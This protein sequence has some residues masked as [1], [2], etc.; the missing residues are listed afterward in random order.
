M[1]VNADDECRFYMLGNTGMLQIDVDEPVKALV[2]YDMSGQ[3]VKVVR[4]VKD[5]LVSL[6]TLNPGV[7]AVHSYVRSGK[8]YTGSF[9][10]AY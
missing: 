10:K 3:A 9:G 4:D 7:Y 5:N 6:S 8:M 1:I 2:I